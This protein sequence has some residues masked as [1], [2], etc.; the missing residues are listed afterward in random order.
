MKPLPAIHNGKLKNHYTTVNYGITNV[1]IQMTF[2]NMWLTKIQL[3]MKS[4]D[5]E[6]HIYKV[7]FQKQQRTPISMSMA[8]Y[9][10]GYMLHMDQ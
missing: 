7:S 2:S 4:G 9:C 6:I 3:N 1:I 5:A 8:A 10:K